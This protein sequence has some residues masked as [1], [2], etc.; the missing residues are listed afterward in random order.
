MSLTENLYL[1]VTKTLSHSRA[2][3]PGVRAVIW[4]QGCTVGCDGCYSKST[5]PHKRVNLIPP[6]ELVSWITSING[7][8]GITLSGGEPFEQA[9]AVEVLITHL[10]IMRPDLSVFLFSG[11]EYDALVASS[12]PHV[13]R[14]IELSD[15]VCCGPFVSK[16]YDVTLLWRGSSNQQLVYLSD[17]YS[18]SQEALWIES[19]PVKE[20][21]M[22]ATSLEYTGFKGKDGPLYRH[23]RTNGMNE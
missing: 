20:I 14:L 12:N 16:L 6:A 5:H 11:Y 1:N 3:G 7:I 4:V 2:N 9:E 8:E 23:L 19:S 13:G 17:R 18:P 21:K 10:K 15:M 22:N